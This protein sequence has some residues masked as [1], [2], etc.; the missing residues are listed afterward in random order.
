MLLSLFQFRINL[1][2]SFLL[3]INILFFLLFLSGDKNLPLN[4]DFPFIDGVYMTFE[5]FKGNCPTYK[6]SDVELFYIDSSSYHLQHISKIK[7]KT[8]KKIPLKSVWGICYQ[9]KPYVKFKNSPTVVG[10]NKNFFGENVNTFYQID[11]IG[12]LCVFNAEEKVSSFQY[13][14]FSNMPAERES[15]INNN[16]ILDIT[17][18]SFY[19]L[20]FETVAFFIKNDEFL[21]DQMLYYQYESSV[22]LYDFI[23]N[24][25]LRNPVYPSSSSVIDFK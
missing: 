7:L 18:G 9:G 4:E 22:N 17:S 3:S 13:S 8:G 23:I 12:S 14:T 25:N 21:F 2:V 19:N 5:D 6:G 20:D 24:Y 10:K 1:T 16:L 11:I 15:M